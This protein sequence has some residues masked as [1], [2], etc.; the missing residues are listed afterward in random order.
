MQ[1]KIKSTDTTH[2][3]DSIPKRID[4][5]TYESGREEWLVHFFNHWQAFYTEADA[6]QFYNG[7]TNP[8]TY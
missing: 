7:M 8:K 3:D 5:N 1:D 2:R 6:V 4:K